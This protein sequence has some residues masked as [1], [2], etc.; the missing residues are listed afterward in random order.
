M[1]RVTRYDWRPTGAWWAAVCWILGGG[2]L[3]AVPSGCTDDDGSTA[4]VECHREWVAIKGELPGPV[5]CLVRHGKE[6]IVGGYFYPG[7]GGAQS[8][9][10]VHS[11]RSWEPLGNGTEGYPRMFLLTGV[12]YQGELLIGG[13]LTSDTD[14]TLI[15][16][17]TGLSWIPFGP[18]LY[19]EIYRLFVYEGNLVAA[20]DFNEFGGDERFQVATFD[21]D[22]WIGIGGAFDGVVYTLCIY[23][24]NLIAG[25]RFG[26]VEGNIVNNIARWDGVA[27]RS[28]NGGLRGNRDASVYSL[29]VYDGELVAG[30]RFTYADSATVVNNIAGWDGLAWKSL[31]AGMDGHVLGLTVHD[32]L[33]VAGG[34]FW[35]A[36]SIAG[37]G[38]A[39]WDGESWRPLDRGFDGRVDA[40]VTYDSYLV[41]G[42]P[43]NTAGSVPAKHIA[44]WGCPQSA[45]NPPR[46]RR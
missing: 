35:R 43:F 29:S 2:L 13:Y 21:G 30:G 32:G 27:W 14:A 3:G 11:G 5:T 15:A 26:R 19:G 46:A 23:E 25:G 16:R 24:D 45:E 41:A 4:P 34:G 28:L 40:L 9:A 12:S 7:S 17:W 6:L 44:L 31:S 8:F 37:N 22:S 39:G 38:I 42:G 36:G 1:I 33:L 18:H 20:G 10:S